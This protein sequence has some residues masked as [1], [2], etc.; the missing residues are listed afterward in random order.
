MTEMTLSRDGSSNQQEKK[1]MKKHID[2]SQGVSS[3][4]MEPIRKKHY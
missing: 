1:T 4:V 3:I 2:M